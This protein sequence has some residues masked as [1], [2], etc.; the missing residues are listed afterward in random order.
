MY[1]PHGP[2]VYTVF[3][4]IPYSPSP[5]HVINRGENEKE[6]RKGGYVIE[7]VK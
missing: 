5:W 4:K 3:W 6:M 7:K 1:L 2:G